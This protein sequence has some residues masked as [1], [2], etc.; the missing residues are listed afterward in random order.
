[1]TIAV[2]VTATHHNYLFS[3]SPNA[4]LWDSCGLRRLKVGNTLQ[5]NMLHTAQPSPTSKC[6]CW[7][8]SGYFLL[9]LANWKLFGQSV[10][11]MYRNATWQTKA[12]PWSANRDPWKRCKS[13]RYSR[14][15]VKYGLLL[16]SKIL[17]SSA[18]R[19]KRDSDRLHTVIIITSNSIAIVVIF[20]IFRLLLFVAA[21][22]PGV[23]VI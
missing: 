11:I 1:M 9:T 21:N 17:W 4:R 15:R 14:A 10:W 7:R 2:I 8:S 19:K 18:R 6:Y 12:S 5:T 23:K 3:R 22:K 16:R 20:S 13:L